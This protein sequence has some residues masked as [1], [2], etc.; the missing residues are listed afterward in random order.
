MNYE[1]F[2]GTRREGISPEGLEKHLRFLKERY[3]QVETKWPQFNLLFDEVKYLKDK[4]SNDKSILVL[5]RAYFCGGYTLFGPLFSPNVMYAVDCGVNDPGD[6]WGKQ[7]SWLDDERCIK[8]RPDYMSAISDLKDIKD[9]SIDVVFIPNVVHHEKHQYKMFKEIARILK[10]GG[11]CSIFE[12]LVRELHHL[13]DDYIRYTPEG[14]KHMFEETGMQ[15]DSQEL[16]TGVF[17]VIAYVWQQALEYLPAELKSSTEKW[18]F[19]EHYPYLQ[20]LDKKYPNNIEK[21]DKAFPMSFVVRA[22]KP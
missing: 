19:D 14:L 22:R 8:W 13:P 18:F 7:L 17:D 9:E 21:P 5:E 12:G 11:I 16:G 15:F 20:E 3:Y 10:P 6:R 1:L 2:Q 4:L